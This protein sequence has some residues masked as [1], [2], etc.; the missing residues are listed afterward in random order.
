MQQDEALNRVYEV[1]NHNPIS[2][3]PKLIIDG[4][5]L[6]PG[7]TSDGKAY[8]FDR[9]QRLVDLEVIDHRKVA[10]AFDTNVY[11]KYGFGGKKLDDQQDYLATRHQGP[12]LMPGQVLL[13]VWNGLNDSKSFLQD[14][15]DISKRLERLVRDAQAHGFSSL[16]G[17]MDAVESIN[18]ELEDSD[19]PLVKHGVRDFVKIFLAKSDPKFVP[20]EEFAALASVRNS[21]KSPPGFGDPDRKNGDF[22]VWADFLYALASADLSDVPA[23]IFVT[24]D[25]KKNDWQLE[26]VPHPFL[27]AE[28]AELCNKPF[29]LLDVDTFNR[30]FPFE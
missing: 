29:D 6:F 14:L 1:L 2:K 7:W 5:N 3:H 30:T 10:I 27:V 19:R 25:R 8:P 4:L 28:V 26:G 9:D 18:R 11:K 24:N 21:A 12:L 20:R 23:V 22:F 13:E 16:D 17:V 15:A